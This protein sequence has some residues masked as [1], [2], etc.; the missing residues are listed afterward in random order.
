MSVLFSAI[1]DEYPNGYRFRHRAMATEYEILIIHQDNTYASQAAQEAFKRVDE[2]EKVLSFFIPNSDVG[3]INSAP[4]NSAVKLGLD[5]F[6]CLSQCEKFYKD[7]YGA[8]NVLY[9]SEIQ[10][11]F[12]WIE[13]DKKEYS[14]V[15]KSRNIQIDLGGFG[16]GYAVDEMAE[17]LRD[18]DIEQALIHGGRSSVLGINPPP[19]KKGWPLT[20]HH[21]TTQELITTIHLFRGSLSASGLQKGD[22]IVDTRPE[23]YK[24]K[25][26]AVWISSDSASEGDALSTAMML[27]SENEIE[28]YCNQHPEVGVMVIYES[29]GVQVFG[30]SKIFRL[31]Y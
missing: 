27:M 19:N 12:E 9:K 25:P 3:R 16:K 1:G 8:F 4:A 7:T 2:L 13:L 24:H 28:Q 18:W 10:N 15:K 23:S 21:P 29:E 17:I 5:A 6:Q 31:G 26:I 20:I 11:P 22:H 30:D 14:F